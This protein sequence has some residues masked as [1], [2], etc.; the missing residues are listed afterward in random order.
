[1]AEAAAPI[2]PVTSSTDDEACIAAAWRLC[3]LDPLQAIALGRG[4]AARG[5][6]LA[7]QGWLHVALGEVRVGDAGRSRQALQHAR[8]LFEAAGDQRGLALC[9][10]T[11][12][13]E[14]R[15]ASEFEASRRLQE[16]VDQ[17]GD[18]GFVAHERFL[19]L[20]SRAITLKLLGRVDDALRDFYRAAEAA[21]DSGLQG[22]QITALV[23]LGGY[24]QDLFNLED[25]RK[26]CEQALQAAKQAGAPQALLTAA[27]NLI[28]IH[29]A[30]GEFAEARCLAGWLLEHESELLPGSLQRHSMALAVAHLGAGEIEQAQAYLEQGAVAAVGDGD[31]VVGWAWL[32]S[33]CHLLQ[34]EAASARSLAES[35]LVERAQKGL[36]DTPYELMQLRHVAADACEAL[37][38]LAAALN[39]VREAHLVYERLV[40]RSARARYLALQADHELAQT[41]RERDL[42]RSS[43]RTAED[44]RRALEE[45]NERLRQ[46]MEETQALHERLREQALRDPLTGLHNR[47]YLFETAPGLLNLARRQVSTLCVVLIDLDHFKLLNDTFGHSAGDGVLQRFSRLLE[48]MLRRSDLVCRYGGEEFVAVMPDI[49]AEGAQAMLTR[50]LHAYQ[51]LQQEAGRRRLPSCSFSAGIAVFPQQGS[52]LEQLLSRADRALYSAK[53]RG[54]ARIEKMPLTD[55]GTLV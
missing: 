43:Q 14:L 36:A 49:D 29:Y 28:I 11:R 24:H 6:P 50:L 8:Q 10:E 12:A 32:Q 7:G 40:G 15:R 4:V 33:R 41:Q 21:Q 37:G 54:R 44:D 19:M 27:V 38:D 48:H 34:G 18:L 45:L 30:Q 16:A 25:A 1:M 26:I 47:R 46:Q 42:A 31:G 13:I 3:Y 52:T 5:G 9:D 39:H 55:F 2:A 35:I 20:N 23:N 22:M 51:A 17:R 53:A